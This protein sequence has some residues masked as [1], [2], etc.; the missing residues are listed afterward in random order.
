MR[1]MLRELAGK[2]LIYGLG[3][4]L[5]GLVAFLLIPFFIGHL[6]AAEYGRFAL[7]EMVLNLALVL[8]NL[9]MN[10]AI[11]ARYPRTPLETRATF[12][13]N[14]LGFMLLSTA[15][16]E[17]VFVVAAKLLASRFLPVLD[18]KT[19]ALIVAISTL[20]TIWLVFATLYR[21]EG[22]A[23]RFI[24]ASALQ[25]TTGLAATVVLIV[26][27]GFREDGILVGRL[28]ADGLLVAFVVLPQVH[29]YRPRLQF[30]PIRSLLAIGLPLIPATFS[31]MWVLSSPRYFI[32]HYGTVADVGVF[33]MSS[34]IASVLQLLFVQPFAMAWMVA[35]F[36]IFDRPDAQRIYARVLTYYALI[37]GTLAICVGLAAQLIVPILSR[38][39]FPLSVG[40]VVV[41]ALAQVASGLMYP[42]DISPYVMEQTNRVTPIFVL[43]A[44]LITMLCLATIGFGGALGAAYA[45]LLVYLI[46]AF[47][48]ARLSQR[49]YAVPFEW[50]RIAKIALS[51]LLASM[52][53]IAL[54]FVRPD[55]MTPWLQ[56]PVFVGLVAATL[57]ALRFLDPSESAGLRREAIK[58]LSKCLPTTTRGS[59]RRALVLPI[60]WYLRVVAL[61][62]GRTRLMSLGAR[63]LGTGPHVV[64]SCDNRRFKL[65]F[66]RDCGWE[67]LYFLRTFETGTTEALSKIL[68]ADDVTIDVGANIGWYTTLF[69]RSCPRGQCHTFEPQPSVFQELADNCALNG[70]DGNV[71][72][73]NMAVGAESGVGR[74]YSPTTLPH[75]YAS[76]SIEAA[77]GGA[78]TACRMTSLDA[79]VSNRGLSR[80]D[81]VKVDVEGAE[82]MVLQGAEGLIRR[83]DSPL[84]LLEMNVR[85]SRLFGYVPSDLLEFL[86]SR[87]RFQF[88]R[89]VDG[90]G[91]FEPMRNLRDSLH[92]D[93]VLCVPPARMERLGCLV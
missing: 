47:F 28:I 71:T 61:A 51:L 60:R 92:A 14:V 58:V 55:V 54:R 87:Q 82:L 16:L 1:E 18:D 68:R 23:W 80:V 67:R 30:A 52:G 83:V 25:A 7:A 20:E 32:E 48:I 33:T 84:W 40:I 17:A 91:S 31:S 26:R 3:A 39:A 46:Q 65:R 15:C 24:G 49:L 44:V 34:R 36:K 11:L 42:L 76:I 81:L 21:A 75:P 9:G 35:L 66:P 90:W 74:I 43:S 6:K 37:G 27:W 29:R 5:N 4:S 89:I 13:A 88:F 62:Y 64:C 85:T 73:N 77:E 79:Y 2:G 57:V 93:N 8:L 72:L 50:I 41:V 53:V 19:I 12:F 63:I 70:L 22:W 56:I 69:A 78:P 38:D 59:L 45:L 86:A 10:V